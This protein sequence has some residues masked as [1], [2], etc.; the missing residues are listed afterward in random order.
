M[1]LNREAEISDLER[2]WNSNKASLIVVYGRRRVGKSSL[3][4]EWGK[5]K[6]LFYWTATRT[7]SKRLLQEFSTKL[8]AFKNPKAVIPADFAYP[9]WEAAFLGLAEYC[10]ARKTLVVLDEFPY[11]VEAEP[12]LPS[13][14][15]RLWDNNFSDTNSVLGLSGSRIG[16]IEN[17][18]ISSRGPLYGRARTILWLDPLE[19]GVLK[20]F[21]PKYSLFQLVEIYSITGGVPLYIEIFDD[22]VPVIEN[23]KRE[24]RAK[25]SILKTDP[26]FLIYDELKEPMRYVAI[27]EAM[28]TGK[29]G[30]SEIANAVGIEKTHI[31][32]YLHTLEGLKYIKRHVPITENPKKSRKGAY[33][34][35]DLFLKFYFRFI[36]QNIGLIESGFEGKIVGE[37]TSQLDSYVGKNGFEE[38]CRKWFIKEANA[39]RLPFEPDAIGRYWDLEIEVDCAAI[40]H[41]HRSMLI[42]EAKWTNKK[43][44]LAVLETLNKKASHLSKK[45]GHHVNKMIFAKSGFDE[46]LRERAKI[47]NVR[48]VSAEEVLL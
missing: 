31:T 12:E 15:Q 40:N 10:R 39:L 48:L 41:K 27:L 2:I 26:H 42:G 37:I 45:F 11:A 20:K 28:G 23:L 5:G 44:G 30:Q 47:E 19:F 46:K 35:S 18:V 7:T 22:S 14:L 9:S 16:I 4:K 17:E 33:I 38:L 3:L 6:P 13:L 24:L 43:C 29:A 21:L 36:A 25:A 32:P 8:Y 1:F 34:I